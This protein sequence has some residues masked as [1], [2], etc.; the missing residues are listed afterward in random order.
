[1]HHAQINVAFLGWLCD[2]GLMS[3]LIWGFIQ[4]FLPIS[5]LT[6]SVFALLGALLFSGDARQ[7]VCFCFSFYITDTSRSGK[8]QM[9]NL[10]EYVIFTRP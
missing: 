5:P 1:M 10:P 3:L 9:Y 2:S 6:D 7:P 4:I 8:E